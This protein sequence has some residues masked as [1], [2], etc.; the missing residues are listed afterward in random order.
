LQICI[1][2]LFTIAKNEKKE[3]K[4]MANNATEMAKKLPKKQIS[5]SI[6]TSLNMGCIDDDQTQYAM[7]YLLDPN[8]F[9]LVQGNWFTHFC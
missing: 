7:A 8:N 4:M 3:Q 5:I 6:D 9:N 2:F 1:F